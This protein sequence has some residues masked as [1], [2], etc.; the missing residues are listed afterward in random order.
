MKRLIWTLWSS[1]VL[2]LAVAGCVAHIGAPQSRDEFLTMMKPGGT[3]KNVDK[4]T[5]SRPFNTVVADLKDYAD[6][7]LSVRTSRAPNYAT[8][9]SGGSTTY[10]PKVEVTANNAAVLSVQEEYGD[11]RANT[12]AP[13]GGIFVL[14][15]EI[16]A[17]GASRTDVE[18]YYV[19]AR[20]PMAEFLKKWAA[21]DKAR[22]PALS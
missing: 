20:G 19:S 9:E 15:A 22:C 10:H 2:L 7:C 13:P 18:I 4:S 8:K 1:A 11:K 16:R 14:A 6:R 5:V 21:G 3:F 17:A 12:G